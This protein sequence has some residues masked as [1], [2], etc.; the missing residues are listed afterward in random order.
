MVYDSAVLALPRG[1]FLRIA[2]RHPELL[3]ELR[4]VAKEREEETRSLLGQPSQT[5]D[6]LTLV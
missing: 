6:D 1:R 4:R 2:E 3:D 5:V